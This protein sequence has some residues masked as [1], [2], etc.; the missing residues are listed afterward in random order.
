MS[1]S[2][3]KCSKAKPKRCLISATT[4]DL[5]LLREALTFTAL[6]S[7]FDDYIKNSLISYSLFIND[8]I[9]GK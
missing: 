7:N 5:L 2:H 9:Y 8:L 4:R 1:K 6:N 3:R